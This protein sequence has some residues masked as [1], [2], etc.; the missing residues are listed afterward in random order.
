MADAVHLEV[1]RNLQVTTS[2]HSLACLDFFLHSFARGH[3]ATIWCQAAFG[4]HLYS[5]S[6]DG[7][8]KVWDIADLRR[9]CLK[10]IPAHKEAVSNL[11]A[12]LLFIISALF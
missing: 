5:G 4:A 9:G 10:T 1:Y 3:K 6:S 12:F 11:H 8:V 7:T 2:L